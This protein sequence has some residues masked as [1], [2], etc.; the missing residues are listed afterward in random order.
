MVSFNYFSIRDLCLLVGQCRFVDVLS[1][2]DL[3]SYVQ[4]VFLASRN[5]VSAR[6]GEMASEATAEKMNAMR[7]IMEEPEIANFFR[8]QQ[9]RTRGDA[10]EMSR[11]PAWRCRCRAACRCR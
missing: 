8:Q 1:E 11:A 2:L 4:Y 10:T 5:I 7:A 9:W 3:M 6:A